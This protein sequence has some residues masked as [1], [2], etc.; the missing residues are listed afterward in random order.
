VGAGLVLTRE[1]LFSPG[2]TTAVFEGTVFLLQLIKAPIKKANTN[3]QFL[4]IQKEI[5]FS[6]TKNYAVEKMKRFFKKNNN[7][8]FNPNRKIIILNE[9]PQYFLFHYLP[10]LTK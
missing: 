5:S 1:V 3:S 7:N 2:I 8:L 10:F 4:N 9:N 6:L